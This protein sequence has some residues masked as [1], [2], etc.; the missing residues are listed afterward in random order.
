MTDTHSEAWRRETESREW[1]RRTN[2]D[3]AKIKALMLRIEAKRGKVAADQLRADMRVEYQRARSGAA[4]Q[5][6]AL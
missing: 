5:S 3:P 4:Q 1:L 6:M 2:A